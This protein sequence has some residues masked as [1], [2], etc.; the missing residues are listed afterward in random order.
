[1][2]ILASVLLAACI[3]VTA[4]LVSVNIKKNSLPDTAVDDIIALLEDSGIDIDRELIPKNTRT[5]KVYIFGTDDY[6][7]TVSSLLTGESVKSRYAVPGGE[8]I[9]TDGGKLLELGDDFSFRYSS[10]GA[11]KD[12]P[13][14]DSLEDVSGTISDAY[15]KKIV[16][17]AVGFLDSGSADFDLSGKITALTE[18]VKICSNG[19]KY[20]AVCSRKIDGVEVADNVAV[21]TLEDGQVTYAEGRWCFLSGGEEYSAQLS[22][23][24]NILFNVSSEIKPEEGRR[25]R[26]TSVGMCYS[27]YYYGGGEKFCLI[28]CRQITTENDGDYI[29]S[30]L[31]GTLYTKK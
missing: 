27:L 23:I 31:D 6:G 12:T 18:V 25:A 10:D 3:I 19:G 5:G 13:D 8:I 21:C 29:F 16:S 15:R 22:D 26:I 7:V 2:I 30:S 1:M 17:E 14:T 28:P 20:Y 11:K 4:I 9:T 24:L